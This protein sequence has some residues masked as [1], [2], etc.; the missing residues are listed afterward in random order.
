VR[1]E[2]QYWELISQILVENRL[3]PN[4]ITEQ[5]LMRYESCDLPQSCELNYTEARL[6]WR[7]WRTEMRSLSPEQ[8]S[9]LMIQTP[10]GWQWVLGIEHSQEMLFIKTADDELMLHNEDRVV[11]L[12]PVV[13]QPET[14]IFDYKPLAEKPRQAVAESLQ[15]LGKVIQMRSGKLYIQTS[16]GEIVVEGT[17]LSFYLESG[18]QR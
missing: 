6:L 11:W 17:D 14:Q 8:E 10:K 5:G 16:Q 13:E 2:S 18:Q 7:Y 3:I 1:Q 15:I 12:S 4:G 9:S